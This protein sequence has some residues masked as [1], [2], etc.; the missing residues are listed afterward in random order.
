MSHY[1]YLTD[2]AKELEKL[3]AEKNADEQAPSEEPMCD[4]DRLE[5]L[6]EFAAQFFP[7]GLEA[8]AAHENTLIPEQEWENYCQDMAEDL[9]F[10]QAGSPLSSHV[11]WE[12]W[13]EAMK[14]DYEELELDCETCFRRRH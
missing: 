12:G 8:A 4:E 2:L 11:D 3:R 7:E 10:I 14:Q 1:Y 9:G 13:A 5:A 6:E